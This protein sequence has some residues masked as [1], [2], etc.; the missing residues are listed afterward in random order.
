MENKRKLLPMAC[1]VAFLGACAANQ[2]VNEAPWL[3]SPNIKISSPDTNASGMYQLGRYYQGQQR[4]SLAIEAYKKALALDH[5][6][7]EAYNGLGVI[8][9]RQGQY[10]VAIEAFRMALNYLPDA[11][12]LYNNLG[13]AYYLQGQYAEAVSA[14]KYATAL[15]PSNQ[16]ALNNLG[17]AYAK[18]GSNGESVQAFTQAA[19]IEDETTNARTVSVSSSQK[20]V[21]LSVEQKPESLPVLLA[22]SG[23]QKSELQVLTLPKSQGVVRLASVSQSLPVVDS[24]VKLVQVAPNVYE[25]HTELLSGMPAQVADTPKEVNLAHMQVEVS[26]GNGV[27]GMASKVGKFLLTQGYS[28]ARLTNQKPFTIKKSQIQYRDGYHALALLLK[29]SLPEPLE[30]IERSDLRADVSMKL[31]LGKDL[32]ADLAYFEN[33]QQNFRVALTVDVAK[34]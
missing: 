20:P 17:L 14:L 26:N 22:E 24:R 2:Q 28:M 30:L 4:D 25:L 16:H 34:P 3:I 33:K 21:S 18:A 9:S 12:H 10:E 8:Y 11:A 32:T 29:G 7:V 13:Y 23:I 15:D 5:G 19:K 27:T 6:F 1:C 31:L